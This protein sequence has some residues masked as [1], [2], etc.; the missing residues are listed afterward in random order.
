[1][2][3]PRKDLDMGGLE[4]K[5]KF[6]VKAEK[7]RLEL[8]MAKDVFKLHDEYFFVCPV[9]AA[10]L[11]K[12]IEDGED[13]CVYCIALLRLGLNYI[14]GDLMVQHIG[15]ISNIGSCLQEDEEDD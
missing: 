7:V 13:N 3:C 4:M 5:V 9:V 1:M 11:K 8:L 15:H 6:D 2:I 14:K 10:S 12:S